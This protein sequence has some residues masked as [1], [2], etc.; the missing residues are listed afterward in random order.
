MIKN[1][2]AAEAT[3][4]EENCDADARM[5]PSRHR[6]VVLVSRKSRA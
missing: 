1:A 3:A 2:A 5:N 4:R 6:A